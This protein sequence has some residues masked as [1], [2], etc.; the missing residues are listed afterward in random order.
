MFKRG[1]MPRALILLATVGLPLGGC[2]PSLEEARSLGFKDAA[3]MKKLQAQ[4]FET[5]DAFTQAELLKDANQ[6]GFSTVAAMREADNLGFKR[7]DEMSSIQRQ[8]FRTRKEYDESLALKEAQSRGFSSVEESESFA[9]RGFRTKNEYVFSEFAKTDLS[10]PEQAGQCAEALVQ[11]ACLHMRM[12]SDEAKGLMVRHR[13]Y[14]DAR[15]YEGYAKLLGDYMGSVSK[16]REFENA[17]SRLAADQVRIFPDSR[18]ECDVASGITRVPFMGETPKWQEAN[19]WITNFNH[20]AI[21]CRAVITKIVTGE[22]ATN[23]PGERQELW[24]P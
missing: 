16:S 17:R 13:L 11:N 8:G 5:K 3:E 23:F 4:G 7:A 9:A 18:E 14:E 12:S 19:W 20:R 15:E 2:G 22:E 10:D 21:D 6:R 1:R 24:R